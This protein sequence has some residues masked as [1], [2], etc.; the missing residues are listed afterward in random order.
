MTSWF[1]P[2]KVSR[3]A[4]WVSLAGA[5]VWFIVSFAALDLLPWWNLAGA[6]GLFVL[7]GAY[8]LMVQVVVPM[9]HPERAERREHEA[10][11]A[12]WRD[13]RRHERFA[14]SS[15]GFAVLCGAV[16]VVAGILD[17]SRWWSWSLYLV[18][19]LSAAFQ[20][21]DHRQAAARLRSELDD[22]R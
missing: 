1:A 5:V 16:A 11:A 15:L 12:R 7:A 20:T 9:R 3:V 18:M 14:R 21:R 4:S 10:L 17:P 2:G 13:P 8:V 19:G 6:S 22:G